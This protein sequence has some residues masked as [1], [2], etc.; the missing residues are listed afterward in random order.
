MAPR[1]LATGYTSRVREI[2][3][4]LDPDSAVGADGADGDPDGDGFT[5]A[6]EF[7]AGTDPR[8]ATSGLRLEV[9]AGDGSRLRFQ[10][11]AGRSYTVRVRTALGSGTWQV[12]R[13]IASQP[14]AGIIEVADPGADAVRF[15]QVSTP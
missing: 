7:A 6:Q 11:Q 14:T 15:Y 13:S 9:M 4:G 12:L 2:A 5:N 10:A 1:W 3:H 8:D